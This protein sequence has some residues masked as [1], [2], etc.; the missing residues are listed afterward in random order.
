MGDEHTDQK[1]LTAIRERM[2][3]SIREPLKGDINAWATLS[4]VRFERVE[5]L[6][7]TARRTFMAIGLVP[8]A[9]P[10]F[11]ARVGRAIIGLIQKL[12]WWYTPQIIAFNNLVVDTME[13][14]AAAIRD[15][16]RLVEEI[17][18]APVTATVPTSAMPSPQ[19]DPSALPASR[20][21]STR[22]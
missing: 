15:L 9:P 2:E 19:A 4:S 17:G 6:C 11:R 12:L 1:L 20:D 14:Q 22:V 10:T 16:L 13:A 3:A 18:A 8:A 7:R 5:E 21:D